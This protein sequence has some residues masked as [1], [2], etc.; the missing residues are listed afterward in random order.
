MFRSIVNAKKDVAVLDLGT[1]TI[2]AAIAKGGE[3]G[4][5]ENLL[6]LEHAIRVLGVGYQ[7][8]KGINKNSI[9]SL[10]ALEE[11]IL[12][13]ISSAEKEAQKSIKSVLVA[14]P[15]WAF[16]STAI[17]TAINIGQLPVDD[18]HL[19][20]LMNF[21]ASKYLDR[22][23]EIV[24]IFPIAYSIDE[25][26][27]IQDP[28]GMVGEKLSAIFHVMTCHSSLLK[29]IK[30][31]LTNNNIEISGFISS[32]Y[33]S[34]LAVTL[35]EEISPGVTLIDIGGTITSIA[36]VHEGALLY[37]GYIPVGSQNIT[38]DIA[39]VLRTTK[40]NAERL[41]ILYGIAANSTIEDESILVSRIDEY[42]EEHIQ[43]V[44][45]NTLDSI[46]SDRLEELLELIQ[47]H[48]SECGA[49]EF[50]RQRIIITGGGSRLSGLNEF[51]KSKKYFNNASVRLGKPIGTTGSHDF[52]KT[53]S[54][55]SAAG[56]VIYCLGDFANKKLSTS[57]KTTWQRVIMWIKRGI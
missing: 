10:D 49:D 11:S 14:L 13:A 34:I 32:T 3:K 17:E 21:D 26:Y 8:A 43:N 56:S 53:P 44:S 18:V 57:G 16:E 37:L 5:S 39:M 28:I 30:N 22:S 23:R 36:C 40:T 2:C 24:H 38:N 33:A 15:T 20:S 54:F 6:G 29:N 31:C 7:L 4:S 9:T 19:N 12:G 41:K 42:G 1:N 45:K 25:S 46:T 27:G 35:D 47:K 50:L 55:A 52:V 51:I 48:L